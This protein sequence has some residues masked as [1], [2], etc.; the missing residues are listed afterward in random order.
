MIDCRHVF[1]LQCLR[2]F[3]NNAIKEGS[4]S[5]VR[6]LDPGCAKR[7]KAKS[8]SGD[9]KT[10]R[11]PRIALNPNELLQIGLSEE[12]VKRYV[13][14]KYKTK[15]ES[16]KDTVYCP[17]TWCGG[18]ARS[19]KHRKPSGLDLGEESGS[20]FND[21]DGETE[22][23]EGSVDK[24]E[25]EKKKPK[26]KY[27][28]NDLLAVCEDC[29]YAFC[30]RCFNS[31]H[32]VFYRCAPKHEKERELSKQE[33]ATLDYIRQNTSPCPTCCSPAQK[34][35]GC[36]HMICYR[37]DTHFCYLCSAWLDPSNPYRH[38]NVAPTGSY[39]PCYMRLWDDKKDGDQ[40]GEAADGGR[41][42]L[43]DDA[44]I[45]LD[46]MDHENHHGNAEQRRPAQRLDERGHPVAI[47]R[48]APL[49]LRLTDDRPPEAQP[50]AQLP[51]VQQQPGPARGHNPAPRAGGGGG[52]AARAGRGGARGRG[53]RGRGGRIGAQG[54][55]GALRQ[56]QQPANADAGLNEAQEAWVR[57]FVQ[58]ALLDAEDEVEDDWGEHEDLFWIR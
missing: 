46:D 7:R 50:P 28:P 42:V 8:R 15:L 27:N 14:L 10:T 37:C 4:L 12:T 22:R 21:D 45:L 9:G 36:N 31:W 39:T 16:D 52:Q 26:K 51:Q 53:G 2:D 55:A 5:T 20:D 3:Y 48:E 34:T 23:G 41:D 54:A 13:M 24:N 33:Q 18:A 47:A 6:C 38:Y 49:V 19:T 25:D 35:R 32:G 30:S 58:M 44:A 11:R 29:G 43:P 40:V 57:R 17:R 56:L 1:C